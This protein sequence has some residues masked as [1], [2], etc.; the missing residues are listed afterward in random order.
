MLFRSP[1]LKVFEWLENVGLYESTN[2]IR[3][4]TT[5]LYHYI[6]EYILFSLPDGLWVFSYLC[7]ILHLWSGKISTQN[8]GWI[9][10]TPVVAIGSEIGQFFGL[11]IGTFDLWDL[12]F[13]IIGGTSPFLLFN[14]SITY[15]FQKT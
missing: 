11:I 3:T 5:P 2:V 13:Y 1:S 12:I 7:L 9:I 6:P 8:I 10:I 4:I 15:N 14:K